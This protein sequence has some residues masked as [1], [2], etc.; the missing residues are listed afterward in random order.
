MSRMQPP[1]TPK[2]AIESRRNL[3][4]GFGVLADL[5]E[6][7]HLMA[8]LSKTRDAILNIIDPERAAKARPV[9]SPL[10][11]KQKFFHAAVFG[12]P[13]LLEK[14]DFVRIYA[15]EFGLLSRQAMDD[16]CDH[17]KTHLNEEEPSLTPVGFEMMKDGTIL[18]RF[19]YNTK[20]ADNAPLMTLANQLDPNQKF[21]K[22]DSSNKLRNTTVAVAICV[23]DKDNLADKLSDVQ[24][25]LTAASEELIRLGNME[26]NRFHFISDYDKRTL[27]LKNFSERAIVEKVATGEIAIFRA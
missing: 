7:E 25:L 22:W 13:P 12:M 10:Y 11:I 19:S 24:E 20:S 26:I 2:E 15:N 23:I 14:N 16:M 1:K 6:N 4:Y 18:A 27:S 21:A 5:E 9:K 3:C 8:L 17:L